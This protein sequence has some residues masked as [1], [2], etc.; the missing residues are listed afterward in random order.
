MRKYTLLFILLGCTAL[1]TLAQPGC[2]DPLALNYSPE[3]QTNDGSCQ[4]ATTTYELQ[5]R[6]ELPKELQE[7]SALLH[8]SQGLWSLNDAG[9]RPTLYRIDS[10]EGSIVQRLPIRGVSN[11]DWEELAQDAAHLYIGDFGNNFGNRSNL[12]IYK[13]AKSELQKDS[14][15]AEAIRFRYSDQTDF[16]KRPNANDY[17]CEAFFF[18][19]DSLHLFS[20]NWI[21]GQT[22]H[23]VLPTT[24][25]DQVAQLRDSFDVSGLITGADIDENGGVV[26]LGYS[27]LI[28]FM[29]LLFDYQDSRFFS[30]NKRLIS[31]GGLLTNGQTEGIAFKGANFGYISSE[32]LSFGGIALSPK[33]QTFSVKQWTEPEIV[34]THSPQTALEGIRAVPNPF[35]RNLGLYL[36]KPLPEPV[37]LSLH[38]SAGQLMLKRDYSSLASGP[39]DLQIAA[40]DWPPG[41]YV[42]TI[43]TGEQK[44]HLRLVH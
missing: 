36:P 21:N 6:A 20:K 11:V 7:S 31:L 10:L 37:S 4:Y 33:L 22:R 17:D 9:N 2:T 18:Y 29:W 26:L 24:V 8:T 28:N 5:P 39:L 19:R 42:L 3:A 43:T 15:S 35:D 12:T 1:S 14:A 32:G 40:Q 23:Y 44:H 38:N 30:G 13:V 41:V 27:G 34:A 25:G 16:T